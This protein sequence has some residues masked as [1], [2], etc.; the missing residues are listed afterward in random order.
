MTSSLSDA[1]YVRRVLSEI[2]SLCVRVA[3]AI[4]ADGTDPGR[5][6][7]LYTQYQEAAH[8]AKGLGGRR[9][10]DLA[11]QCGDPDAD[12][13]GVRFAEELTEFDLP[14]ARRRLHILRRRLAHLALLA[15]CEPELSAAD[16]SPDVRPGTKGKKINERM[17]AEIGDNPGEALGLSLRG[18]AD[19]FRCSISTIQ[20]TDAWRTL[21]QQREGARLARQMKGP[22]SGRR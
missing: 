11:R 22:R 3:E 21:C 2:T 16:G 5:F 15:G 6:A 19:R 18:W 8:R 17:L 4:Q 7:A 13:W 14:A 12:F 1:Q 9:L 20:G 10:I